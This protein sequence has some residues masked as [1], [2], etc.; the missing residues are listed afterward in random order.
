MKW[1]DLTPER[2]A[3]LW[4][5]MP[6]EQRHIFSATWYGGY[7]RCQEITEYGRC[8]NEPTK[9]A[10]IEYQGR[11]AEMALCETHLDENIDSMIFMLNGYQTGLTRDDVKITLVDFV[12]PEL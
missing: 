3:H 1:K 8:M 7:H 4:E 6:D 10:T 12:E 9:I 11:V 2:R 5:H